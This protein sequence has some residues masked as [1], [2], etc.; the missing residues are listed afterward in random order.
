MTIERDFLSSAMTT[1]PIELPSGTPAAPPGGIEAT[2]PATKK[3]TSAKKGTETDNYWA[4][5]ATFDKP[6]LP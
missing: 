2:S 6:P 4:V 3:K 5:M 1:A